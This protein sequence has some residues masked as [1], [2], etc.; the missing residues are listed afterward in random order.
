MNKITKITFI[1]IAFAFVGCAVSFFVQP[2]ANGTESE[3]STFH[4]TLASS[5]LYTS[6]YT[7]AAV[8]FL[9]GVSAYKAKLRIAY[10]AIAVG[11]VLVGVGLAQ[12]VLLRIFG[13]LGSPWV[14]YGG[15]MLPF[16]V[17]G[18]TIY[19]GTRSRAKLVGITSL[20]T[21]PIVVLPLLLA[22]IAFVGFLPHSTSSLPEIF[23]DVSNAISVLDVVFYAASLGLVFQV[24]NRS[25]IHYASSMVW[26][27]FGLIGSVVISLSILL[28]TLFTG[29]TPTGYLLD[30]LVIIGGLLYL[31]AGYSFAKTKEL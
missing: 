30:I 3:L 26:L 4:W 24:K 10:M 19:L 14:L 5:V 31:K 13:L 7:G 23:F 8:L 6:L 2:P 12:V 29:E 27:M 28:T 16:V 9:I 18:L 21:R 15:I 17:A 20:L 25:G 1:I 11:I 22:S